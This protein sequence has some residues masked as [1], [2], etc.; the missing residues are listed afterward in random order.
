[1]LF[2]PNL[3]P[4]PPQ[5][6]PFIPT[7]SIFSPILL[8]ESDIS[9]AEE[10]GVYPNSYEFSVNFLTQPTRLS[11]IQKNPTLRRLVL[12]PKNL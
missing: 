6:S 10:T 9:E 5:I 12:P 8:I 11:R 4:I 1:M 7:L 3:L 2:V